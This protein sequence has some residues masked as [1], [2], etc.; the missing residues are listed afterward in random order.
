M[1]PGKTI[2]SFKA[3]DGRRVLLR[4]PRLEDLDDLLEFINSLVDER[5]DIAR[6]EK[7]S[8]EEEKE[9]LSKALEQLE[10]EEIFYM[11]A[12][13][14]N[15]VIAN[16]EIRSHKGGYDSHVGFVGIAIKDGFR[17]IGI[18]TEMMSTLIEQAKKIGLKVLVLMAFASNKRAIHVYRK[19][20]FVKTGRIPKR[21]L[22]DGRFIDETIMTKILE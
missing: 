13:V 12:E 18:G 20:G 14:E 9:W 17:G 4:T 21:F 10:R 7:V 6:C 8:R 22:R 2:K 11:V 16:S 1:K 19:V 5:A 15:K 3:K